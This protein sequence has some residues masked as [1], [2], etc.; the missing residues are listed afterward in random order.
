MFRNLA[1]DRRSG[2]CVCDTQHTLDL[3]SAEILAS[4][5]SEQAPILLPFSS[6]SFGAQRRL[7]GKIDTMLNQGQLVQRDIRQCN[8]GH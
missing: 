3:V 8:R 5:L 7:Q 2:V 4:R 1:A 6:V